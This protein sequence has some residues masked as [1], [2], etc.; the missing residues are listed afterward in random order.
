MLYNWSDSIEIRYDDDDDD[1]DDN[2]GDDDEKEQ[3]LR[4]AQGLFEYL[5]LLP[6]LSSEVGINKDAGYDD[7]DGDDND[8][9]DNDDD[10]DKTI[11][12]VL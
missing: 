12:E 8:D 3:V 7:N 11:I 1:D 5:M 10:D 9:D 4:A 2:D 6:D